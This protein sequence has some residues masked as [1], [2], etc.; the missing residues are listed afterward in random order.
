V[1]NSDKINRQQPAPDKLQK[2]ARQTMYRE[3]DIWPLK[4]FA[5]EKLPKNWPLRKVLLAER[6]ISTVHEF[7]A[8]L[9]TWQYL[10][11]II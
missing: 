3:I 4:A 8:K 10:L 6:D 7:L 5:S 2:Q 1:K 11:R 9:E